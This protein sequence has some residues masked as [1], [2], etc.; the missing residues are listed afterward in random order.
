MMEMVLN[1]LF[2]NYKI[3]MT[4][5]SLILA[6]EDKTH[7]IDKENFDIFRGYIQ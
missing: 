5:S 2:P 3:M 6:K 7:L 4:P 1:L